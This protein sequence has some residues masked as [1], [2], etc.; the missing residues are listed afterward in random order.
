MVSVG[1]R[2]SF[3]KNDP[4]VITIDDYGVSN[5]V[6]LLKDIKNQDNIFD[7]KNQNWFEVLPV[8]FLNYPNWFFLM[9]GDQLVA[10][11]TIQEYYTGCYRVLTRTYIS[12][13]YRRFTNPRNDTFKSP[14]MHILPAQLEWLGN[15][16]TVFMSMQGLR[17][18]EAIQRF[19]SKIDIQLNQKWNLSDNMMQTCNNP[20][21]K[22]CWQNIIYSGEHPK[23]NLMST[24]RYEELWPNV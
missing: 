1:P 2:S 22:E 19:A 12:R 7:Q 21:D 10:F 17:R 24:K 11:S 23:L 9:D 14:T 3:Y 20:D 13:E 5:F 16:D 6:K 4:K 18:R 8:T 15:Y